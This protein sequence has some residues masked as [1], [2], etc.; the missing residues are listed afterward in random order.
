MAPI[1]KK[2]QMRHFQS[3]PTCARSFPPRYGL[4]DYLWSHKDLKTLTALIEVQ[5]LP[6]VAYFAALGGAQEIVLEKHEHYEKQTY[7][8]RCYINAVHGREALIVPLT[9][10]HGKVIIS[11]VRV[12]YSQKWLNNHWRTLQSA[13]G[14]APFFEYYSHDLEQVLFKRWTFLYDLNRELLSMCLKWLKWDVSVKES[15]SYVQQP[16]Q[17]ISDL[18]SVINPKNA[19]NLSRF[20]HPVRYYQVFGN[21]FAENLSLVDLIFC[22]GPQAAAIVQQSRKQNE[23]IKTGLRF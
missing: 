20:Y 14:K 6:S 18:R 17:P 3:F 19:V 16:D 2:R 23:Q 8:N 11:E 4:G 22:E 9:A 21:T 5:Y 15:L 10:K 13:Y 1:S 12:D 7:R